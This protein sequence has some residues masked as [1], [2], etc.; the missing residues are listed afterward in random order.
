MQIKPGIET[1]AVHAGH[2][3]DPGTDAVT[4]AI[5]L[6]TTFARLSDGSYQHPKVKRVYYPGLPEHPGAELATRQML[7]S[8][9]MVS[10]E[11]GSREEAFQVAG[12]LQVFT[13]ATSLGTVKSLV[14]IGALMESMHNLDTSNVETVIPDNLLRLS[15]GIEDV[16]TLIWDLEQA[17]T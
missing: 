6:S 5:H 8:G 16:K 11:I 13:S 15:V 1:L 14:E 17:L 4:P 3:L 9:G 2:P 7:M 12:K 10:F